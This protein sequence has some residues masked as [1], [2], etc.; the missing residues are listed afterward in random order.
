[1][2]IFKRKCHTCR[3]RFE[4]SKLIVWKFGKYKISVCDNCSIEHDGIIKK[5]KGEV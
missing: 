1:M 4:Y 5:L 2:S 3:N